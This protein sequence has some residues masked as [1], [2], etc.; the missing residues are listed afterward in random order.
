VS[1]D[2]IIAS[3]NPSRNSCVIDCSIA[4]MD[5]LDR[6]KIE[7]GSK[8]VLIVTTPHFLT[9][10]RCAMQ[11]A[12]HVVERSMLRDGAIIFN[13]LFGK[14][15]VLNVAGDKCGRAGRHRLNHPVD[16]RGHDAKLVD[17]LG[18]IAGDCPTR[19]TLN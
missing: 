12:V 1:I 19:L 3:K 6:V 10:C 11:R 17:F 13:D 16:H 9:T 4:T 15:D 14:L 7:D 5:R 18:E 8:R 2:G